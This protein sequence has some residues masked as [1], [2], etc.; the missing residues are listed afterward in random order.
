MQ[1]WL[2]NFRQLLRPQRLATLEACLIGLVAGLA[3]VILKQ[4]A[5]LLSH[6]RL[7]AAGSFGWWVLPLLGLLGGVTAGWLV[8]RFAPEASGSGIPQVKAVLARVPM[9]LDLRVALV[10]LVGTMVTLGSGFPLGREGPTIQI[11]AALANQLS[12]WVPTSP[13]YRRQLVAAGAGAGLAAAFDA[14]IAGVIFVVEQLLQNVSGLTLGVAILA[15]F[16]GAVLSRVLGGFSF[17][18]KSSMADFQ[19]GFTVQEIP[20]YLLLGVMAGVLGALY[21]RGLIASLTFNRRVLRLNMPLRV[22]LAGLVMGGS[23]ALLPAVFRDGE[24]LRGLIIGAQ[25]PWQFAALAFVAQFVLTL[26]AYGSGAPGGVFA[27][28][29]VLG[30]ALGSL[31]GTLSYS[32]LAVNAPITYSLVGMGAFFCA[33]TRV[34]I[35]AVIIIFEITNDFNLVLPLMV[36]CVVASLVAERLNEGSI[37]DQLLAWNGIRLGEEAVSDEKLLAQLAAGDVMQ[38]RLETLESTL[39][40]SEVSQ[41]FSRSH[42]RGFPVVKDEKLV[43][44]V[45]QT[46]LMKIAA[47]NLP[48]T[49]PLSELMTPQPVTVTPRDSL[50][51]VLYL[52]NRYELSRLPVVEEA[53]LVGIITRSDI[54]RAEADLLSGDTQAVG[55]RPDPSYVVYQTRAPALGGGRLLLPLANP[56]TAPALLEFALAIARARNLELECLHV[57]AVPRTSAPS[58]TP[59]A[60]APAVNLV[61]QAVRAGRAVGVPVHT[62]VRVAHD[63]A[64]A[65][66]ETVKERRIGLVLMGWRGVNTSPE[67]IFSN[68]VDTIIRQAPCEVLLV[69]LKGDAIPRRWLVP[70]GGGPNAQEAIKILPALLRRGP[71]KSEIAVCQVFAPDNPAHDTGLLDADAESLGRSLGY[72]VRALPLFSKSVAQAI[73]QCTSEGHFDGVIIGASRESL[74]RQ[75]IRGNIPETVAKGSDCTVVVVRT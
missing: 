49:A 70:I 29:L 42:H 26:I 34:P 45:T 7:D 16:I 55:P 12:R 43:G 75:A 74:L 58:S 11:G 71:G 57:I 31:V 60:V 41:A 73:V 54:I 62:Q 63:I 65:V 64:Q 24:A 28:S 18:L 59:V 13:A 36:V 20:F 22:G 27:P 37:Y 19:T 67:R 5:D 4:G 9:A 3:A 14:P 1:S 25:E 51:E 56:D 61:R 66:L 33:V 40:L 21:N 68:T 39:P 15:S 72:P 48:P 38:T 17:D 6:W 53:K 35:T 52:L 46:D 23:L 44:I 69:K 8:E 47:R 10:K 50:K 32:T 2:Q 30:A